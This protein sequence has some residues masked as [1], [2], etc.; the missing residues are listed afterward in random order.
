MNTT[1][2]DENIILPGTRFY[3][4]NTGKVRVISA[5][6]KAVTYKFRAWPFCQNIATL[7]RGCWDRTTKNEIPS[8]RRYDTSLAEALS[9]L[10]S[11]QVQPSRFQ[12][13]KR[14]TKYIALGFALAHANNPVVKATIS[15]TY[16]AAKAAIVS[17]WS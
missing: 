17:L 11:Y 16:N 7:E 10:P 12:R 8:K 15:A 1:T 14:A 5:D 4:N 3:L 13:I 6:D 9:G 2:K